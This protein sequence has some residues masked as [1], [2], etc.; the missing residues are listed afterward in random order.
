MA[1]QV[2]DELL[3]DEALNAA[4]AQLPA[5]YNFEVHKT[6]WRLRRAKATRVAL[7]LPEGLQLFACVLSDIL[8]KFAFNLW[9]L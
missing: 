2:P 1:N 7:Q 5:N 3:H 8:E 6:I 9:K 4:I